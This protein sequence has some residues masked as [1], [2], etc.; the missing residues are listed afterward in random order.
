VSD[1]L[2]MIL[3]GEFLPTTSQSEPGTPRHC[4]MMNVILKHSGLSPP[5]PQSCLA[6]EAF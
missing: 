2:P 6:I 1:N 5:V 4:N 3:R